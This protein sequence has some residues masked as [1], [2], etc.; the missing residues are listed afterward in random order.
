[1]LLKILE[2]DAEE[3]K[4]WM[5]MWEGKNFPWHLSFVHQAIDKHAQI[6]MTSPQAKNK[7]FVPLCGKTVDIKFLA[8]LGNEVVGVEVS[9][10]AVKD[11]FKEHNIDYTSEDVPAV[12]GKLFR[13]ND[14]KHKIKLYCCDLFLFSSEIESGF[15]GIWD[16]GSY[17]AMLISDRE[18][19]TRV[20]KTL[21]H[22]GIGY[23]MEMPDRDLEKGPPYC[24]PVDVV[25]K[26]FGP[27]CSVVKLMEVTKNPPDFLTLPGMKGVNVF[28]LSF[29]ES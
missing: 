29:Q 19:Y 28:R 6:L 14:H 16:R 18:R 7:I 22:P 10:I 2:M 11:F 21:V 26:E 15:S 20:M 12:K 9:E 8:D 4:G 3:M 24:V 17:Q 5:D 1:M 13:S 27:G 25:E 23:L